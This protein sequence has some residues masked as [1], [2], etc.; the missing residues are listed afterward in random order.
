LVLRKAYNILKDIQL[1]RWPQPMWDCNCHPGP[2][3]TIAWSFVLWRQYRKHKEW[4]QWKTQ[5][6]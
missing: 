4:D 6:S 5:W 3:S 1:T 2:W